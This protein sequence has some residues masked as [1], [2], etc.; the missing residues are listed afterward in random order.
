MFSEAGLVVSV[1]LPLHE[2][3]G[4]PRGWAFVDMANAHEAQA[5]IKRFNGVELQGRR[6][7]VYVHNPRLSWEVRND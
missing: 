6:L 5:A 2:P 7:D 3:T 1:L 4:R